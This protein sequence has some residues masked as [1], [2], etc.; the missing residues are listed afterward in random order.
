M[1]GTLYVVATPIGNLEDLTF[2][3]ARILREVPVVAAEDTRRSG[4]LLRHLNSTAALVS[5]HAHNEAARTPGLLQRLARGE[6]VALVSDAGTPGVSDPGARLVAAA[7]GAGIRVEPV[8]GPSAVMAALSAAGVDGGWFTFA[9]FP[10]VMGKDRKEWLAKLVDARSSGPVV[11]FEAPHRI[12]QTLVDIGHIVYDQIVVFR[13]LTKLHESRYTGSPAELST[14]IDPVAGEFTLV[15][16]QRSAPDEARQRPTDDEIVVMFGQ[17]TDLTARAAA[18]EVA[19]ATG[20]SANEVYAI[21]QR[22]RA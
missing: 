1:A 18:R 17:M 5:V 6:S 3:A 14:R 2:R 12:V 7:A 4:Q 13:E 16:P 19:R 15:I 9:G 11:A 8:P 21:V 20:L 10:P 22:R